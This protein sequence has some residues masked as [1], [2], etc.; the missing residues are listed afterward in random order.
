MRAAK[1]QTANT[2]CYTQK[3]Q[4]KKQLTATQK[5]SFNHQKLDVSKSPSKT[6]YNCSI[7]DDLQVKSATSTPGKL[8]KQKLKKH[9]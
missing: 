2:K 4:E 1:N 9:R 5:I 7:A 8:A 3:S 6:S